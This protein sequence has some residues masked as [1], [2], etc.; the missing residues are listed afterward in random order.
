MLSSVMFDLLFELSRHLSPQKSFQTLNS[1]H[2]PW[3]FA[4]LFIFVSLCFFKCFHPPPEGDKL[5]CRVLLCLMNV[6]WKQFE[7]I[8]RYIDE[9]KLLLT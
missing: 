2:F 6:T 3:K 4:K 5:T 7:F 9:K 8:E 1:V